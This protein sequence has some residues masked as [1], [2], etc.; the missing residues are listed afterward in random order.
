LKQ[1]V[2]RLSYRTDPSGK[3][4]PQFWKKRFYDFSVW[5]QKKK[6]EKLAYMHLNPVKNGL[7][8]HPKEWRW[9]S[10]S[11]YSNGELGL[12]RIDPVC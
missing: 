1:R 6:N 2:S 5:S 4:L 10:F 9:N 8:P 11:F 12:T 3:I 7:V